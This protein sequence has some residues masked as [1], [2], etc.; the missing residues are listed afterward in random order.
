M[1]TVLVLT[2]MGLLAFALFA[3]S[4]AGP[5]AET[6]PPPLPNPEARPPRVELSQTIDDRGSVMLGVAAEPETTAR[7]LPPEEVRQPIRKRQFEQGVEQT[8]VLQYKFYSRAGPKQLRGRI[9]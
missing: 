3:C 2:G 8:Q 4:T 7:R 1:K 9:D 5:A 6:P